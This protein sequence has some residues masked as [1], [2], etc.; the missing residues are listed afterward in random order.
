MTRA[1]L[2]EAHRR[3]RAAHIFA[4]K[5][6]NACG[7]AWGDDP[8]GTIAADLACEIG[9]DAI[10]KSQ[11]L[12]LLPDIADEI[13]HVEEPDPADPQYFEKLNTW[14]D[15]VQLKNDALDFDSWVER[16]TGHKTL[17]ELHGKIAS[18][19]SRDDE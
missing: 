13:Q 19:L 18:M 2:I 11:A 16:P 5:M 10:G 12:G 4:M 3:A 7:E 9:A 15:S 6:I 1:H 17:S 8:N 14:R